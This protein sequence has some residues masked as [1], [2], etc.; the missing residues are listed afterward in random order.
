MEDRWDPTMTNPAGERF[1]ILVNRI[2][3]TLTVPRYRPR[4]LP[5][6]ILKNQKLWLNDI[7]IWMPCNKTRHRPNTYWERHSNVDQ[8]SIEVIITMTFSKKRPLEWYRIPNQEL[9]GLNQQAVFRQ[10]MYAVIAVIMIP[11]CEAYVLDHNQCYT[12]TLWWLVDCNT[13]KFVP[14]S[15][16]WEPMAMMMPG[17]KAHMNGQS[18]DKMPLEMTSRFSALGRSIQQSVDRQSISG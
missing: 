6:D 14:V 5:N 12:A 4:Y 16:I 11:W 13:H 15:H 9:V 7:P 1:R 2:T 8:E 3:R 18:Q 17:T 10:R